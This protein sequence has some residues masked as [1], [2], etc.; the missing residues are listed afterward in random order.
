MIIFKPKNQK[1]YPDYVSDI[2]FLKIGNEM[3]T[4]VKYRDKGTV[5]S[6]RNTTPLMGK[7]R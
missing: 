1:A 3:Y 5:V 2:C 4:H 6:V 7:C